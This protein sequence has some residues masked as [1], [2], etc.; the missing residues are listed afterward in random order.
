MC[1]PRSG[2]WGIITLGK[3]AFMTK[4][5]IETKMIETLVEYAL[6]AISE[7]DHYDCEE[8]KKYKA[9]A[10]NIVNADKKNDF[11]IMSRFSVPAAKKRLEF[12]N[13]KLSELEDLIKEYNTESSE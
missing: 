12:L 2:D 3:G 1:H 5:E 10:E 7:T 8:E 6:T 9:I 4:N 11:Q 13:R